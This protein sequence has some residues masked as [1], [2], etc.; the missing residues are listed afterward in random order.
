MGFNYSDSRGRMGATEIQDADDTAFHIHTIIKFS[1][2]TRTW[3]TRV[4]GRN[5]IM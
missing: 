3:E 2:L 4:H 5:F 1:E